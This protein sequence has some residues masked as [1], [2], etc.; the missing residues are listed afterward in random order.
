MIA[1]S[2]ERPSVPLYDFT[3]LAMLLALEK[4]KVVSVSQ[5]CMAGQDI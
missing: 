3:D 1:G 2:Q 5:L 4:V